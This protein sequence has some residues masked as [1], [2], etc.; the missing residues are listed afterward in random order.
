[1]S[2]VGDRFVTARVQDRKHLVL[3]ILPHYSE[4]NSFELVWAQFKHHVRVKNTK[5]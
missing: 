3:R 5:L 4:L 1:M 2:V